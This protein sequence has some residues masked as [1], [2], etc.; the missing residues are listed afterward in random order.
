MDI[1]SEF[2]WVWVL[3]NMAFRCNILIKQNNII[4][5][6]PVYYL[7]ILVSNPKYN[8]NYMDDRKYM[9]WEIPHQK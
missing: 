3:R 4:E 2:E 6:I 9:Y 1:T 8:I 5:K 7:T